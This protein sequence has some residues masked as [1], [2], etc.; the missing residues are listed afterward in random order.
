MK[1]DVLLLLVQHR[2]DTADRV[3]KIL[4]GWGCFIKTRL[5]LH[6]GVLDNCSESGLIFL[7]LV[8]E[9][10]KHEEL[11]RK[12]K[13]VKGVDAQLVQLDVTE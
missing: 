8:G 10:A 4:T 12:L 1:R 2:E 9:Q 13:L 11:V 5:G 7:E 3:Q 6:D